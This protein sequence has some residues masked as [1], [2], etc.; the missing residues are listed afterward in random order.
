MSKSPQKDDTKDVRDIIQFASEFVNSTSRNIFLTGK[1]GT[2]K[3][4]FL[5]SLSE[6]THKNF[7]VVAPTGIAALNAGG[8]TIH[9]Q[10]L[11]PLGSFVPDTNNPDRFAN[12]G[13]MHT[14][15]DLVRKHP[16]NS[17]RRQVLRSIELLVIDEVSML[18]ADVL[19]AIDFRMK[20]VRNNFRESFGGVQVMFIGDLFQLPPIVKDHEW[21][22]LRHYYRSMHFFEAL[23]LK[24][25]P[26]VYIELNKIFRQEDGGFIH[27]LNNLRNNQT[28]QEDLERLNEH[29]RPEEAAEEGVITVTTHNNKADNINQSRLNEIT[30]SSVYFDATLKGD[31]PEKLYPMPDRLEL[32]VGAQVMFIRN[33]SSGAGAYVNGQL[34][35]VVDLDEDIITVLMTGSKKHFIVRKEQWENKKYT[36]NPDSK[37]LEED[38]VGSFTQYPLKLAWAVT[39]HKSQGLTFERAVID[40]GQ[41]FAPG[42]VYVALSRLRSLDGLIL[43]TKINTRSLSSDASVVS[44]TKSGLKQEPLEQILEESQLRYLQKLFQ[45]TFDFGNIEKQLDLLQGGKN[46]LEFEDDGMQKAMGIV[47]GNMQKE[48]DNTRKFQ[49][50]LLSLL[51]KQEFANLDVRL[52][53]GSSYYSEILKENLSIVLIH[54]SEV[55]QFSRTKKYRNLLSE[56]DQLIYR[57]LVD[58]AKCGSIARAIINNESIDIKLDFETPVSVFRETLLKEARKSAEDNPKIIGN[59]SGRKRKKTKL[60]MKGATYLETYA[61]LKHGSTIEEVAQKRELAVSTIKSHVSRGIKEGVL[62]INLFLEVNEIEDISSVIKSSSGGMSEAFRK[63]D[64][65]V[66][67]DTLRMVGSYLSAQIEEGSKAE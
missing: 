4:T 41:A 48:R 36:V 49:A 28:N 17:D 14:R 10:F 45:E 20:K 61:M 46:S 55:E 16:L 31:F 24:Q 6:I 44:Y 54:L 15:H 12:N 38:V 60:N 65:K 19:D 2:G 1:A 63:L 23:V 32:R 52:D 22:H 25:D 33:D 57:S 7:V 58:L 40:V 27:I 13:G 37:E 11:F 26:P 53:K 56:I 39:V 9:S 18:R 5:R 66:P 35:K 34:A 29:Y 30:E 21:N 42:Q 43:K 59:K 8:V 3:T 62:D 67:Y 47:V 50:Q 51:H 64:G